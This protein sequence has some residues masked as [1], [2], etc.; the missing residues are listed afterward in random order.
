[1]GDIVASAVFKIGRSVRRPRASG[2]A[3]SHSPLRGTGFATGA[4]CGLGPPPME[5]ARSRRWTGP[6]RSCRCS[7]G[8]P[9]GV[10]T[11]TSGTAPRRCSPRWRSLPARS[12][13]PVSRGTGTRSSSRSS[14]AGA[15]VPKRRY[16]LLPE[17]AA[18]PRGRGPMTVGPG[19]SVDAVV[20]MR[21]V[22]MVPVPA[23]LKAIASEVHVN[24]YLRR[25]VPR[26]RVSD[27]VEASGGRLSAPPCLLGCLDQ[28]PSDLPM[29]TVMAWCRAL[30]TC[31]G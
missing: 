20:G 7:P 21:S 5:S 15:L 16:R 2:V 22:D 12:P 6:R 27:G 24:V 11:T 14:N 31:S 10:P 8:R 4:V 3:D 18:G 30:L 1:M 25:T 13:A 19:T 29:C 9:S 23:Q 26:E 28:L 17:G